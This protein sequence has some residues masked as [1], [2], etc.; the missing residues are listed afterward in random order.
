MIVRAVLAGVGM[1]V[2][3]ARPMHILVDVVAAMLV[4]VRMG[5]GVR[6]GMA[7]RMGVRQI[8]VPVL[9]SMDM[10]VGMV[11]DMLVR[12]AMGMAVRVTVLSVVHGDASLKRAITG[13]ADSLYRVPNYIGSRSFA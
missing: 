4:L 7:V 2:G 5:V 12:M 13:E 6:V 11:V 1:V 9:V 8:A 10:T 3:C